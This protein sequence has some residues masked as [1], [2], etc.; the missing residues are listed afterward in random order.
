MDIRL[1]FGIFFLVIGII[2]LFGYITKNE[3]IFSN[4]EWY[5]NT[6]GEKLGVILHF[7]RYVITPLV[8]GAGILL[9]R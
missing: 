6:F 3:K 2:S 7:V 4:K 5:N 8:V 1:Y 9:F